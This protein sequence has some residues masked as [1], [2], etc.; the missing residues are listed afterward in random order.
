ME[1]SGVVLQN[2]CIV[3]CCMIFLN[4]I[5]MKDRKGFKC[6]NCDS[7]KCKDVYTKLP[8]RFLGKEGVF[9]Y[10]RCSRCGLF[11]LKHIPDN[12]SYYYED[13]DVHQ[14]K[15]FIYKLFFELLMSGCYPLS[16]NGSGKLLDIGCGN[17]WYMQKMQKK[18]WETYGL[19]HDE[20]YSN[21][22]SEKIGCPVYKDMESF[23]KYESFFDVITFNYSFEHLIDPVKT[24][25]T[26][27]ILLKKGGVLH[28]SVP[29]IDC[30]EA[31]IF[32]KN[33]FALDAPR[34]TV[35]YTKKQLSDLL[36]RTG[37]EVKGIKQFPT[38]TS[39]AGS[40]SYLLMGKLNYK[41]WYLNIIPGILFNT[42]FRH[43]CFRIIAVKP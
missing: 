30:I 27:N 19:E 42:I 23:N 7:K 17:G 11:Q 25:K 43:T 16:I 36:I 2:H 26:V 9:D 32:A 6:I 24:L 10:V 15:S 13:Y 29:N 35:L 4:I 18:G 1:K 40:I 12:M 8:D 34:H 20:K 33:W 41:I 38:P 14:D 21:E 3:E 37:F 28:I 22:I 5:T 39:F 31:K